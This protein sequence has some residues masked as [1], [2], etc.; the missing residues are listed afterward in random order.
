MRDETEGIDAVGVC[1]VEGAWLGV[2]DGVGCDVTQ[3][4]RDDI[5]DAEGD[6]VAV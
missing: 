6:G 2:A 3:T 5:G 4:V 1:V